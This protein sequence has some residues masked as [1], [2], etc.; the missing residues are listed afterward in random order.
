MPLG[1][2]EWLTKVSLEHGSRRVAEARTRDSLT[3]ISRT[4]SFDERLASQNQ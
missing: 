1:T 3:N 2:V 4:F